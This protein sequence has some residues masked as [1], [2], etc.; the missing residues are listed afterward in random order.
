MTI[1]Q[2]F[3]TVLG[4]LYAISTHLYFLDSTIVESDQ[5]RVNGDGLKLTLFSQCKE[6][7]FSPSSPHQDHV[8][9]L[10]ISFAPPFSLQENSDYYGSL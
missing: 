9:L 1:A 5:S 4:L 2:A 10:I 3:N 7:D 6:E 8:L